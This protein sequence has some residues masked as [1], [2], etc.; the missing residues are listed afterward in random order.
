MV[1][2]LDCGAREPVFQSWLHHSLAMGCW[3]LNSGLSFLIC[4]M[5]IRIYLPHL[6]KKKK[7]EK[8]GWGPDISSVLVSVNWYCYPNLII[9]LLFIGVFSVFRVLWPA[10]EFCIVSSVLLLVPHGIVVACSFHANLFFPPTVEHLFLFCNNRHDYNQ[11][12]EVLSLLGKKCYLALL[13]K[14]SR[15]S[16]ESFLSGFRN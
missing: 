3:A 15:K 1:E 9:T 4:K 12:R 7:R 13:Y 8:L 11:C 14:F 6:K 16:F 2:N 5:W 10:F